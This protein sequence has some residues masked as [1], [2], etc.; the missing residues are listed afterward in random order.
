MSI[1]KFI[2]SL[3]PGHASRPPPLSQAL[4][5][6]RHHWVTNPWHAV[7]IVSSGPACH[8]ARSF[9]RVR[10]L[11]SQA[12]PLPLK[13]CELRQCSCH[14]RH[15]EDRR[16]LARRAADVVAASGAYWRGPERRRSSGR[17]ITDAV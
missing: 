13:G 3:L 10:F 11:S 9:A 16:R 6:P 1:S 14:Y 4:K 12:P 7:S 2:R 15:H 5:I 17:R 8:Q